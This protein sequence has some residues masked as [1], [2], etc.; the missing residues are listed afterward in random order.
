ME[1]LFK[2]KKNKKIETVTDSTLYSKLKLLKSKIVG[3]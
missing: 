3:K 1:I 2:I